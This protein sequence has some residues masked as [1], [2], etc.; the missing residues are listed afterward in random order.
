MTKPKEPCHVSGHPD[1][2]RCAH[3]AAYRAGDGGGVVENT[4]A[5]APY[6]CRQ[7]G[8]RVC[9]ACSKPSG[10]SHICLMCT[11]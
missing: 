10:R 7:C 3:P 8:E 4:S 9:G 6:T 1:G 5:N 2:G 11:E